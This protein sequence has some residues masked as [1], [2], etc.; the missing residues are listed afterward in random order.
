LKDLVIPGMTVD[1]FWEDGDKDYNE[2]K[3]GKTLVTKTS[4]YKIVVAHEEVT[5]VVLSSMCMWLAIY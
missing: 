1:E 4:P 2:F 5:R 3:Y